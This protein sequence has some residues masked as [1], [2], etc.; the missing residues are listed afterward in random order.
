MSEPSEPEQPPTEPAK[1]DH[2]AAILSALGG[3]PVLLPIHDGEKGPKWNAW[4]RLAWDDTQNPDT[5]C[6]FWGD[7][8][9][10]GGAIVKDDKGNAI[11]E[12]Y[13]RV[14]YF[15]LLR[16]G[17]VGVRLGCASKLRGGPDV[18]HLCSIDIDE[19]DQ[20]EPFLALNPKL[21][22]TLRTRG[23]R[24]CNFWLWVL[25]DSYPDFA[26]IT[27]TDKKNDKGKPLD[28]GEWRT[29]G[30]NELGEPRA[31]QTVIWGKHPS[32]GRYKR[33]SEAAKPLLIDF[34]ELV[35][36]DWLNYPWKEGS[37]EQ[38]VR[39]HG[40]PWFKSPNGA[41]QLN[42][43]FWVAKYSREHR[44]L[45]EP[46]EGRFYDY[47]AERGLWIVESEDKM[48]WKLVHDFKRVADEAKE[49]KLETKRTNAFLQSIVDML[50]GCVERR[51][52]F[53]REAGLVHLRNCMLDLRGAEPKLLPFAHTFFSRNQLNVAHDGNAKCPRFEEELLKGGIEREE[54]IRLL[55][56]MAGQALLG[57]NL[58][59]K[60]VLLTGR[61]GRGK[62]TL[63]D[64]IAEIIG[65]ANYVGLR[66]EQ[67]HQ[68]F[69]LWNYVGKTLLIGADVPGHFLM[70]EGAHVLKA[71]VG[72]DVLTAEKKNGES[73]TIIGD[74]NIWLSSNS[75]LKVRLDGDADAWRRRLI[76]VRYEREA[77]AVPNPRFLEEL[78]ASE[79]SG[80]LNWM[81]AG[82]IQL[83]RE[84]REHGK[85]VMDD[86]QRDRVDSLLSESD[87]VREFVRKGIA[88]A[89]GASNDVTTA[90][91]MAAYV[92]FCE[93]RSWNPLPSRRVE[94]VLADLILEI[95]RM[96]RRNDIARDG[97][98]QRGYRGLRILPLGERGD[99][100]PVAPTDPAPDDT[101][102]GVAEV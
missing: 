102:G 97:K 56:K 44:V 23:S 41:L 60:I 67:L 42:P 31:F 71:L 33:V 37:F 26:K 64:V 58:T 28:W 47:C 63:I 6:E 83:L 70:T 73:V 9:D 8:R 53:Q 11:R 13:R 72:K 100:T 24:G 80:I 21:A 27:H 12:C 91:L 74:Y 22:G 76:I 38:L 81:V 93:V 94:Q 25:K 14:S 30:K 77:P 89:D 78:L 69:E 75:R 52:A 85:V 95:H 43:P 39:E 7:K 55:Q 19:D 5:V 20:V 15:E 3:Q 29:D 2:I 99:D 66:T 54:D 17:N 18:Y 40:A 4:E 65:R 36:P 35:W 101:L 61:A 86:V 34:R 46:E 79:A 57:I 88:P 48:R 90:E 68:R 49:P 1:P 87:S 59:Q 32:G 82:A 51:E 92:R 50:K 96:A 62:T 98:A 84:L 16:A 45:F 10:S